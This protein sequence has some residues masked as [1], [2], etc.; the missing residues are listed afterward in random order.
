MSTFSQT[1]TER[2]SPGRMVSGETVP[3]LT[4]PEPNPSVSS[5]REAAAIGGVTSTTCMSSA[6]SLPPR[7][8]SPTVGP[9]RGR[10]QPASA[11]TRRS[12]RAKLAVAIRGP[13]IDCLF[14]RCSPCFCGET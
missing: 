7:V 13:C 8:I 11:A 5:E 1:A 6:G 3:A 9:E 4:K 14:A 12:A 2:V 10:A